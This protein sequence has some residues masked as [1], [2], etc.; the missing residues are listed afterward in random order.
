MCFRNGYGW[1]LHDGDDSDDKNQDQSRYW[2][3]NNKDDNNEDFEQQNPMEELFVAT[4][5]APQ[6]HLQAVQRW[7]C[8]GP[9]NQLPVKKKK[10]SSNNFHGIS[11]ANPVGRSAKNTKFIFLKKPP[12]VETIRI[13]RKNFISSQKFNDN[14]VPKHDSTARIFGWRAKL[15][16]CDRWRQSCHCCMFKTATDPLLIG[17]VLDGV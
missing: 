9:T 13:L 14:C 17:G 12:K 11:N 4:H 6:F 5:P 8:P 1:H 16:E 15:T 10:S 3:Q 7:K 2:P